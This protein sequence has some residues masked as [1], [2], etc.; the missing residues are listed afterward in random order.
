MSTTPV[1][2][3]SEL[4]ARLYVAHRGHHAVTLLVHVQRR[5]LHSSLLTLV[6]CGA[7]RG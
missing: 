5:V 3:L 2:R 4:S 6:R 1:P 7:V